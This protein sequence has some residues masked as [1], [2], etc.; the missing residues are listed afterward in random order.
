[1]SSSSEI[2]RDNN[3]AQKVKAEKKPQ[4]KAPETPD[5]KKELGEAESRYNKA[6]ENICRNTQA[7]CNDLKWDIFDI[8][9]I[10][11]ERAEWIA[12]EESWEIDSVK[13]DREMARLDK[14]E[15]LAKKVG[16]ITSPQV[17]AAFQEVDFTMPEAKVATNALPS[18]WDKQ[19]HS[20]HPNPVTELRGIH[21]DIVDLANMDI[22]ALSGKEK[23]MH[24]NVDKISVSI[25]SNTARDRARNIAFNT[26]SSGGIDPSIM[27]KASDIKTSELPMV[28]VQAIRSESA[29]KVAAEQ[30]AQKKAQISSPQFASN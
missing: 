5:S 16:W 29:Q 4:P 8:K 2:P 20:W 23:T 3:D 25:D 6:K 11:S 19:I 30:R 14:K 10:K 22:H 21:D 18:K 13:L 24:T 28:S 27:L 1:M 17:T 26:Q 12:K 9:K 15:A 7:Q